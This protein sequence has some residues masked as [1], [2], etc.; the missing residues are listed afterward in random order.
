MQRLHLHFGTHKTGSTSIQ[1]YLATHEG[2]LASKGIAVVRDFDPVGDPRA[3]AL[4]DTNCFRIAH[5]AIRPSLVTPKRIEGVCPVLSG[6]GQ[7]AAARA[8]NAALRAMPHDEAALS[9]EAF[10]FLRT[11][12]ERE[13][14]NLMFEGIEV[15]PVGFFRD[16]ADWLRSWKTQLKAYDQTAETMRQSG[17]GVFDLSDDSWLLQH[18]VIRS[19]FGP[20]GTYR[21]YEDALARRGSVIPAFL[22]ALGLDPDD[23]PDWSGLWLHRSSGAAP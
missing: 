4:Y 21:G 18:D 6:E 5:V 22:E 8:V 9:A 11:D 1:A 3:R 16:R 2:F 14:M 10:S 23:C 17:A 7:K 19:F 12:E 13:V 15:H 20:K